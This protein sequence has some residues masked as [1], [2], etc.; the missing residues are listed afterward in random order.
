VSGVFLPV[1]VPIR[2]ILAPDGI[3]FTTRFP[4]EVVDGGSAGLSSEH[5]IKVSDKIVRQISDNIF[6]IFYPG[7]N[8]TTN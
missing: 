5:R 6:I 2:Y 4:L 1:S 3:D 7:I 8:A